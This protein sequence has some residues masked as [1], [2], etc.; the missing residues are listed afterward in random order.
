MFLRAYHVL[1]T[2]SVADSSAFQDM[3][4]QEVSVSVLGAKPFPTNQS[5]VPYFPQNH[6][7]EHIT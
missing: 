1:G 5:E 6:L 3:I 2:H 7:A 4:S